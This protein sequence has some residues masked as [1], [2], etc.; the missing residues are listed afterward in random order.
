MSK[1]TLGSLFDGSGGFPF[2]AFL[3]GIDPL[4][5][6]EVEPFPIRVTTKR[7][8]NMKHYG[9]INKIDGS[10]IPPVDIITAGF[11]C[12]DLSVAGKRAGLQGERSGLFYQIPRIIKEMLAATNNTYPKFAVLENVPGMYSSAGGA[13]F[14]EVLNELI[15]I[16][17]ETLSVPLPEK[18]KWST[19]GEIVGD[20]F[21]IGWRT[22]DAQFWGVA[23]R[24]RR[25]YI[26]VDFT[27][28]RAGKILFD[29]SRL[30][31]NPPQGGFPWQTT[32]GSL[33][34][35]SGNAVSVLNDQGGSYMDV[36]ENITG[37]LRSQ[38]HG[39]QP[40]VFEPGAASRVGGHV[41][42]GEPTGALRAD[43]GDNQLAVAIENHPT[44]SRIKIDESGTVQTLTE[45]M[46]TGGGNVP[47]VMNER[48]YA[49]T[50]G[51]DVAN[52]LTGTDFKGTQCVFEPKTLKIRSGCEGGGKGALIQDNK[53]ATLSTS[54][55]QTMFVP[56][57]YGICSMNSNSMKSGNPHSGIYEAETA[58]TLDT[59][60]P[61]PNKNAGGMAVVAVEGNGSRPSHRGDGYGGNISFTL[62]S[63]ERHS[64]CYQDKV[65]ALCASDYKFPQQQQIEEGKAVVERV[66]VENYQHSGYRESDTAGTLKQSGG[67]NGGGSESVIV[68]NRYVVRRLTPTECALL[69]GFPPDWCAGL[70]SNE[71][72]EE[73]IAFWS[74]VWETHRLIV[75]KSTKPKS[76]N[77]IMKWL[78]DPHSDAAEYKM[79]GNGVALPCVAFVLG[80]IVSCTQG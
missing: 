61:D 60:V 48:Q 36:S 33:E 63:V 7:F 5:A 30:S 44:D 62:N 52:T 20:S 68:E 19:S 45:R 27:G 10:L 31:G 37:T 26:V 46:G 14:Q 11:C 75:G 77:Q 50:V 15:Q 4:W 54:N 72:T 1:L 69:Q 23:Q 40:I 8:P 73:D 42:Q 12:Q 67:T 80:G 71:P 22:L 56:K 16:K 2:G 65:G 35:G 51:E 13:D 18:G 43:M 21:S 17:D 29:E 38:E 28:E 64:V 79:W 66:A 74:E 9:D 59:S 32:A 76:R 39:H 24:R 41:W 53:S 58:R 55:D 70:G 78:K 34:A 47:L 57:V 49:L 6:S 25:C 3:T